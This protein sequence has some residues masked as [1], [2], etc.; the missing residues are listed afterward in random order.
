MIITK[1]P[2]S[3][4]AYTWSTHLGMSGFGLEYK[5]SLSTNA[6]YLVLS[7]W[8]RTG[9]KLEIYFAVIATSSTRCKL[10][11]ATAVLCH[12]AHMSGNTNDVNMY[13]NAEVWKNKGACEIQAGI[14]MC[15]GKKRTHAYAW[16]GHACTAQCSCK[17]V[18]MC[19][20]KH[21]QESGKINNNNNKSSEGP[22]G[23]ERGGVSMAGG[24]EGQSAR[25]G[26]G[27]KRFRQI[28]AEMV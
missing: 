18:C 14:F 27:V 26:N 28:G 13:E 7:I 20:K 15:G 3:V 16:Y 11:M 4:P 17:V 25:K 8:A 21:A 1:V 23:T 2:G 5:N 24:R 10:R 22:A 9:A 19:G 12:N 6:R